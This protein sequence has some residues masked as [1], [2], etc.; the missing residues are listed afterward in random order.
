[1]VDNFNVH[2]VSNVSP[3]LFPNNNAS[4]FST[5]L[6]N[7]INL[8]EGKW[9][10]GVRHIMY[11]THVATTSIEDKIN[12]YQYKEYYRDLLP[13]P[14]RDREDLTHYGAT[15][16][17]IE[18][19]PY[20]LSQDINAAAKFL[21]NQVNKSVWAVRK[22]QH[23]L[24]LV[25]KS[26]SKKFV[27]HI[28]PEDVV[29]IM[30]NDL[31]ELLGFKGTHFVKGSHWTWS[32]FANKQVDYNNLKI[33]LYDLTTLESDTHQLPRSFVQNQS[34]QQRQTYVKRIP[35]KFK[36]TLPDEYYEEP[37][38]RMSVDPGTGNI[39]TM[40]ETTTHKLFASH[41]KKV[42][43]F[44][45]DAESTKT[46]GL[47]PIYEF[48]EKK[49][50]LIPKQEKLIKGKP[51][52]AL[53][54][55]NVKVT[56][57]YDNAR[58]IEKGFEKK[59]LASYTVASNSQ[60]NNPV[61]LLPE[62]N[63][64]SK[65]YGFKFTF[66][67]SHKRYRLS[68]GDKYSVQLTQSLASILGFPLSSNEDIIYKPGSVVTAPEFPVLNRAITALYVY[69][70]IIE[71]VYIGNVQAPLLLTCPFTN[72]DSKDNVHQLEFLNPCYI[73][74]NR[75]TIDQIDIAIYDDAGALI[76]FLHGKTKL[77]LDFRRVR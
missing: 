5:N 6:A 67:T 71:S 17:L 28:H 22:K 10:V 1:M 29:I 14:P 38:F 50:F 54:L 35:R 4:K 2:L 13:H 64:L 9:E 59:P 27:L 45:F 53:A 36:D 26:T 58:I 42:L 48:V 11:P 41:E 15:I 39:V 21:E 62:L 74:L 40:P 46:L 30:T 33:F 60:V 25:Y 70:N 7:E 76:P 77:S 63:K 19:T 75:T 47:K 52:P 43:F 68:T 12:I 23:I 66:D 31:R 69:S 55:P 18:S 72:K 16:N 24:N 20:P 37:T 51:N 8:T 61:R 65:E 34:Q 44:S 57:Y 56:L 32:Q 73:P 3:D 49:L